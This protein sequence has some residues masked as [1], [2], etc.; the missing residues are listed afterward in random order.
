MGRIM[1]SQRLRILIVDDNEDNRDLLD[2]I[3]ESEHETVCV[4]SGQLCLD[5]LAEGQFDLV[6]LDVNMPEMDGYEVCRKIKSSPAYAM[7]PVVFVSALASTE[8]RLRGYE[9]GAE[10]YIT[11]PFNTSDITDVVEKVRDLKAQALRYEE[12]NKEAMQ[13]AYQAMANSAELGSIVQYLQTSFQSKSI[14]QLASDLLEA[15]TAFG[16]NC[17]LRFQVNYRTTLVGCDNHSIEAKVIERFSEGDKI[18]D[19][20]SRTLINED[21]VSLLVK[22]MPLDKPDDYGRI[23]DNLAVLVC[24]TEARCKAI[25][26]EASIEEARTHGLQSILIN[27]Q[28]RLQEIRTLIDQQ[29]SNANTVLDSITGKVESVVFGL[30][31]DEEQEKTI[32]SAIDQGIDELSLLTHYSDQIASS[33]SGFVNDLGE[34]ASKS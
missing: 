22:N 26:T 27:S 10:D 29:K 5:A 6:L 23:K 28:N 3:L 21:H 34:I 32:L 8:E 24:G 16:L 12:M 4:E 33:F 2:D 18:L 1:S 31:L 20:G 11:K 17:C 7:V 19:F 15:T 14:E 25:E 13:T 9:V 30:G